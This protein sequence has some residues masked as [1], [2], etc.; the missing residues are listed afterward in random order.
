M[1]DLVAPMSIRAGVTLG[2]FAHLKKAPCSAGSIASRVKI[3][4]TKVRALLGV[5]DSLGLVRSDEN[6]L[7]HLTT[8]GEVLAD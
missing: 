2:I 4:P 6:D 7:Y 8:I 5:L 3:V 1:A